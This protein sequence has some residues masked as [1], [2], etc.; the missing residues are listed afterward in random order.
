MKAQVTKTSIKD[1][2][3]LQLENGKPLQVPSVAARIIGSEKS[4]NTFSS[5]NI[6][7]MFPSNNSFQTKRILECNGP[8]N[9]YWHLEGYK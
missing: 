6:K 2:G 5:E 4:R 7:M 9:E 8:Q 1:T 3:M